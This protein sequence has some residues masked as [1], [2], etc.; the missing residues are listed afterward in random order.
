MADPTASV[1]DLTPRR[2]F[3]LTHRGQLSTSAPF[4]VSMV[5][6]EILPISQVDY[7]YDINDIMEF[8][9][10]S[11]EQ[12]LHK[13]WLQCKIYITGDLYQSFEEGGLTQLFR[14]VEIQD[15]SGRQ[16]DL[17][18]D[19]DLLQNLKCNLRCSEDSIAHRKWSSG[20]G[21]SK[22]WVDDSWEVAE[23]ATGLNITTLLNDP[24]LVY[25]GAVF[26]DSLL[27]GQ[28][29]RIRDSATDEIIWQGRAVSNTATVIQTD[30]PWAPAALTGLGGYILEK[31][32]R[33]PRFEAASG[34]AVD[35]L[36]GY[37]LVM[38]IDF[39]FFK[40]PEDMPLFLFDGLVLR[41]HLNQPRFALN[42]V[43]QDV[44]AEEGDL[45]TSKVSNY[46][47][48]KPRMVALFRKASAE[49][50]T[51]YRQMF[52]GRGIDYMFPS[53]HIIT[54]QESGN[55]ASNYSFDLPISK[56]SVR[57]V[58]FVVQN[59]LSKGSTNGADEF[60]DVYSY[61]SKTYVDGNITSYQFQVGGVNYPQLEVKTDDAMMTQA[62]TELQRTLGI[63]QNPMHEF[64]FGMEDWCKLNQS[65]NVRGDFS[66]S[67]KAIFST[68]FS[69]VDSDMM[70]GVR[71]KGRGTDNHIICDVTLDGTHLVNAASSTRYFT[72]VFEYAKILRL[73]ARQ[74]VLTLE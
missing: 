70:T 71:T 66:S 15:I 37:E 13:M 74:G 19:F 39:S 65:S 58:M 16:L 59:I 25:S 54:R 32:R 63:Q 7:E 42:N 12:F 55:E 56:A 18:E 57:R 36:S 35:G 29:L 60:T 14:R 53:F 1:I 6:R 62:F 64:R 68:T 41:F 2:P 33:S 73:T 21:P 43:A 38:D 8:R 61:P 24:T 4:V 46:K 47:I 30:T 72:F 17:L 44:R 40:L 28:P 20:D 22:P 51:D 31:A 52:S 50:M 67:K 3:K 69:T 34:L 11:R 26:T 9:I 27:K 48:V 45:S 23:E 10:S 49:I 5:K